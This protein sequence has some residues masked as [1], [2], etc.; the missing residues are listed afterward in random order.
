MTGMW[1]CVET[2]TNSW[3]FETKRHPPTDISDWNNE[4]LAGNKCTFS[5]V[6]AVDTVYLEY[7]LQGS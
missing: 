3:Y 2:T 5:E 1:V 7:E 4:T 6:L